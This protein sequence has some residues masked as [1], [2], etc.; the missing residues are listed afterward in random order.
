MKSK[1][2]DI[3][4][5][6]TISFFLDAAESIATKNGIDSLTI[7]NVA[8]KAGYNSAT[9][10]NYFD[11]LDQLIAFMVIRKTSDYLNKSIWYFDQDK[12]HT[13]DDYIELWKIFCDCSFSDPVIYAYAYSSSKEHMAN[14]QSNIKKYYEIFADTVPSFEREDSHNPYFESEPFAVDQAIHKKNVEIG[15]YSEENISDIYQFG[16]YLYVG[17][18]ND[19]IHDLERTPEKYTE[20]FLHFFIPFLKSKAN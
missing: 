4:R 18:L 16:H 13:L 5:K 20:L 3:K 2:Y 8:D 12:I 19:A 15:L 6:R 7:R 9:I 10:Y 17:L 11:N 14:Y 1:H